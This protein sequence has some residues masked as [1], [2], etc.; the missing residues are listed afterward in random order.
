MQY[1]EKKQT[2]TKKKAAKI[3]PKQLK[4]NVDIN[5]RDLFRHSNTEL[6]AKR[7]VTSPDY[8][9]PE[10]TRLDIPQICIDIDDSK[11][12]DGTSAQVGELNHAYRQFAEAQSEFQQLAEELEDIS[13]TINKLESS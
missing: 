12:E 13:N 11:V 5:D 7:M 1:P 9:A 3:C 8:I 10:N 2:L 4:F 6:A